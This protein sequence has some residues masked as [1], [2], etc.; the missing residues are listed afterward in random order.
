MTSRDLSVIL[1]DERIFPTEPSRDRLASAKT[2][3][4]GVTGMSAATQ[5][6][7]MQ[8]LRA[9]AREF[10]V[11]ISDAQLHSFQRYMELLLEW[12]KRV[13]LISRRDE[14]RIITHHFLDSLSG[15][16]VL[17]KKERLRVVEIGAGAGLPGLPLK[18]CRPDIELTL[19]E[20]VRM[21]SLFLDHAVKVLGLTDVTV[22][23]ERAERLA[24]SSHLLGT[25]DVAV[26]RAVGSLAL[27][28]S[29]AF[30]LLKPGGLLV[31]YKGPDP[32]S[33]I[34][35]T[36]EGVTG[37]VTQH[38]VPKCI[39]LPISQLTRTLVLVTKPT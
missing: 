9:G 17:P 33:E 22:L 10:G 24:G 12:N 30:P 18:I 15:L 26:A 14:S 21:K 2:S 3:G 39:T 20:S 34:Q 23:R 4:K 37:L 27:L 16:S 28:A 38:I 29:L 5:H 19:I 7:T 8:D 6:F 1:R 36:L 32:A 11:M 35:T 13:N 25:Y 31:A